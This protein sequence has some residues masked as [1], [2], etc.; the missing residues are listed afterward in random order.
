MRVAVLVF[1]FL[2]GARLPT[3]QPIAYIVWERSSGENLKR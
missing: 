1:L 2:A 3:D